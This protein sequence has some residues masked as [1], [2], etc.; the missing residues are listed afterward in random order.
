MLHTLHPITS[1]ALFSV[2]LACGSAASLDAPIDAHSTVESTVADLDAIH[3]PWTAV[4]AEH[5][6][7]DTF[8]YAALKKNRSR[9]D[10]YIAALEAVTPEALGKASKQARFVFWANAYNA[11]TVRRVIDGYPVASIRDLGDDKVSVWDREFV[12]LGQLFPKLEKAK[13]TLNDI[14]NKILRPEFQDA[15]VH[16]AINC[17][18]KGCPPL[19]AEA[20]TEAKLEEQLD[21]QVRVWLGD[22]S[23][24]RFDRAKNRIEVSKVFEWFAEDFTKS[25]V[26]VPAWIARFRPDD[27]VWLTATPGPT[28][29]YVDYDWSLND[30]KR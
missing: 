7:G 25:A 13:L 6:R 30:V 16:A 17:A 9:L 2:L 22:A 29:A 14:E 23:R 1:A 10:A 12:P 11:Y 18:S 26:S 20:F 8:D 3:A 24:N 21:A 15:R 19:R 5:V 28:V 4:L 27:K